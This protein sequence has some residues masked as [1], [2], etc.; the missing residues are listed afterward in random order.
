MLGGLHDTNTPTEET[1]SVDI[2]MEELHNIGS[3]R[4]VMIP[5]LSLLTVIYLKS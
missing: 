4:P 2:D 1:L 5:I 3:T